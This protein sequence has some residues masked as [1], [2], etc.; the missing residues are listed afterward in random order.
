MIFN[1]MLLDLLYIWDFGKMAE[2]YFGCV[3]ACVRVCMHICVYTH[4]CMPLSVCIYIHR[5]SYI[6]RYFDTDMLHGHCLSIVM[7]LNGKQVL[8][9]QTRKRVPFPLIY[10]VVAFFRTPEYFITVQK[11]F[12]L[13]VKQ[14]LGSDHCKTDFHLY[15]LSKCGFVPQTARC[16]SSSPYPHQKCRAP[17]L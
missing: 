6:D 11:Y 3:H 9:R 4:L 14:S 12:D 15:R 5:D 1:W 2:R 7:C 10:L 8:T 13:Y 17:Q 16:S